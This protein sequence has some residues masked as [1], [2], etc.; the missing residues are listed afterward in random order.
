MS[1]LEFKVTGV[2][3]AARGL[4][5]LLQFQLEITNQPDTEEIRS[6]MLQSQVQIQTPLR[7]YN[8]REKE[9]LVELFGL[10]PEWGR[11]LRTRLWANCT[12]LVGPFAGSTSA[13]ISLP[14]TYDV[15]IAAAKY[16]YALES[17]DVPLL[18]LFSGTVFHKDNEGRLQVRQISWNTEAAYRMPVRLWQEMMEHHYPASAWLYIDRTV[19]DRL[20]A[21]RRENGCATWEET[22]EQLLSPAREH[23]P[24]FA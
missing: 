14:C 4:T 16:C 1:Q 8:T 3:P 22:I 23:K 9:R 13:R 24:A 7:N 12:T 11:T 18:F 21:Y 17:G 6:I 19:F 5:P 10:P 20:Y 2:E 15:N